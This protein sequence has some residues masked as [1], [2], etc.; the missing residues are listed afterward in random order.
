[1][2]SSFTTKPWE[3]H[4]IFG[5]IFLFTNKL[6]SRH[7]FTNKLTSRHTGETETKYQRTRQENAQ[8]M[9]QL[10][11]CNTIVHVPRRPLRQTAPTAS[12]THWGVGRGRARV[13]FT[14]S[15]DSD[16]GLVSCSPDFSGAFLGT[17]GER[18]CEQVM[19]C[20]GDAMTFSRTS[21]AAAGGTAQLC[22]W[23]KSPKIA[24]LT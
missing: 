2:Q 18:V 8:L 11:I 3:F 15:R 14:V 24:M 19:E 12:N 17:G 23:K 20:G 10:Q 22:C 1:M 5:A 9:S 6:T 7:T 4:R 13:C 21:A 16:P